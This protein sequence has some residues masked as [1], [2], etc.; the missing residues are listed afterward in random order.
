MTVAGLLD[1]VFRPN[2]WGGLRY[3]CIQGHHDPMGE[4]PFLS[5]YLLLLPRGSC[6][7]LSPH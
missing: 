7:G 4:Y 3:Q 6:Y 1:T 5:T 2:V